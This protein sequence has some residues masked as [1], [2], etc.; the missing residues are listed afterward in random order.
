MSKY[1]NDDIGALNL[2]S[3]I[4]AQAKED[5]IDTILLSDYDEDGEPRVLDGGW[6]WLEDERA[7]CERFF[8]S[9]Y[10]R[11]L[12]FGKCDGDAAI[13]SIRRQAIERYHEIKKKS[14]EES[15]EGQTARKYLAKT[16][17]FAEI[18]EFCTR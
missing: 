11:L 18:Y 5:Y 12:T 2:S 1:V 8:K 14:L 3:A 13:R 17:P 9:D 10:F 4:V 7:A 6:R 16:K 15:K